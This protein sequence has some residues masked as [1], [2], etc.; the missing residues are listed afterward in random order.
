MS[1]FCEGTEVVAPN[2]P[3]NNTRFLIMNYFRDSHSR[4]EVVD[5]KVEGRIVYI[6]K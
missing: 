6:K 5:S 1:A 4:G 2:D 3:S